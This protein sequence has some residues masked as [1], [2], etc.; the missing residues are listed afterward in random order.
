MKP[1]IYDTNHSAA[2]ADRIKPEQFFPSAP[3]D[4]ERVQSEQAAESGEP[5]AGE[6]WPKRYPGDDHV[7]PLWP[8]NTCGATAEFLEWPEMVWTARCTGDDCGLHLGE[9]N[10]YSSRLDLCAAWN[11]RYEP[12]DP[13]SDTPKIASK[14]KILLGRLK[15][16][17]K[18]YF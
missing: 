18:S 3:V 9:P 6:E 13:L 11:R 5:L 2:I 16:Q 4:S 12:T 7:I 17:A 8:C 15:H 10:G 14:I 1:F